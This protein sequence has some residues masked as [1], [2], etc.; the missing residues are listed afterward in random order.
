MHPV[1]ASSRGTSCCGEDQYN[2]HCCD[3]L[4]TSEMGHELPRHLAER[5]AVMAPKAAAPS[6]DQ[7]GRGGPTPDKV[8]HSPVNTHPGPPTALITRDTERATRPEP[9]GPY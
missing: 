7:G 6:R 4:S 2:L 9:Q 8:H 3:A 5:A 1:R